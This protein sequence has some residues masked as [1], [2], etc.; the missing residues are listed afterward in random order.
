M[1]LTDEQKRMLLEKIRNNQLQ[2][3]PGQSPMNVAPSAAAGAPL[4]RAIDPTAFLKA[5]RGGA[6]GAAAGSAQPAADDTMGQENLAPGQSLMPDTQL[7]PGQEG[8]IP[9]QQAPL[10]PSQEE[11]LGP[12]GTDQQWQGAP[13]DQQA[14]MPGMESEEEKKKKARM[15]ALQGLARGQAGE[16]QQVTPGD[17]GMLEG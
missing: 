9:P 6:A 14:A 8:V 10:L 4:G 13:E 16:G 17:S 11:L 2:N 5:M 12:R 1:P 15:L 7:L 3:S